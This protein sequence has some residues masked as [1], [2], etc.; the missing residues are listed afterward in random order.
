MTFTEEGLGTCL[1]KTIFKKE[2]FVLKMNFNMLEGERTGEADLVVDYKHVSHVSYF[3]PKRKHYHS[4]ILG[5]YFIVSQ[6]SNN[7]FLHVYIV[8]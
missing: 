2:F 8:V 6:I 7:S 5:R 3:L 1:Y 4:K